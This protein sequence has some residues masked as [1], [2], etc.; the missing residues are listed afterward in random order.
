MVRRYNQQVPDSEPERIL[1]EALETDRSLP[2]FRFHVPVPRTSFTLDFAWQDRGLVVEVDG[3][4]HLEPKHRRHDGFRTQM[5]HR[6]GYIYVLRFSA[7][8]V[9]FDT[10][11]V[12][13][14]IRQRLSQMPLLE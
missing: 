4:Q 14:E 13:E 10:Q 9:C 3:P 7:E 1:R 12:V 5:L 11:A 2:A 8:R 6:A